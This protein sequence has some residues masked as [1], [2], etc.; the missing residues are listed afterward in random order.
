[1]DCSHP[2]SCLHRILQAK[3]L[4]WVAE[5]SKPR[6]ET[7]VSC[8]IGRF[9]TIWATRE[10]LEWGLKKEK[11]KASRMAP[12]G[13]N[14]PAIQEIQ[15]QCLGCE[16]TQD[17]EMATHSSIPAWEVPWTEEPDGQRTLT[18]H[19]VTKSQVRL[20]THTMKGSL[21]LF[22]SYRLYFRGNTV[23]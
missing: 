7:R 16:D 19:G 3:I 18:V 6:D 20:N 4:E 22:V 12:Q 21:F 23:F 11:K 8:F 10:A 15:V 13:K 1:M 5:S 2:V 9:F 14:L 17:K